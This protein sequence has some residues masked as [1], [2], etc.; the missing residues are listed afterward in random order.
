MIRPAAAHVFVDDLDS[1]EIAHDDR[2][3]LERVLRLRD[4]ETVTASDGRGGVR[5]CAYVA[6]GS[7]EPTADIERD[8]IREPLISVGFALV[9]GDRPEWIV[10]KLTECG[11]DSIRPFVAAR[12]I[13]RW[14]E[15]KAERNLERLRQ[16]AHGAAMQSRQS[17]LAEVHPVATFDDL[18]GLAAKS[19]LV[20]ADVDGEPPTVD[21]P[22]VLVGPEGGWTPEEAAAVPRRMSL[23]PS[24]LRAETA[25][26]AAGLLLTALRSGTVAGVEPRRPRSI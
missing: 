12:S 11:V 17:W 18:V 13:V 14:D 3:H 23:G 15:T 21:A 7:L 9:K 10:Q 26:L 19:T 2:H 5:R 4:G 16:V 20:R 22:F 24:V 8:A 25:A 6:G 1:P